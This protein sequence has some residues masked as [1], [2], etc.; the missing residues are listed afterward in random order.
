MCSHCFVLYSLFATLVN[1][2]DNAKI[3][4]RNPSPV[5]LRLQTGARVS[6]A[7]G[8]QPCRWLFLPAAMHGRIL[9]AP[10]SF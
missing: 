1:I 4:Q 3:E 2:F 7:G 9:H 6:Y 10:A 8:V 5:E